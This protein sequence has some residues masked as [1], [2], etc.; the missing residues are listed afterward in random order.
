MGMKATLRT[1]PRWPEGRKLSDGCPA[2]RGELTIGIRDHLLIWRC[3]EC[4]LI[5]WTDVAVC[6]EDRA[7]SRSAVKRKKG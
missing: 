2:C 3:V 6:Y 4:T 7:P 5:W 1:E